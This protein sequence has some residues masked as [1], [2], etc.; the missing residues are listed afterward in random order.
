M[1]S[2]IDDVLRA[3]RSALKSMLDDIDFRILL[4]KYYRGLY[5]AFRDEGFTPDEAMRILL[6]MG[7]KMQFN[8]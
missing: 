1:D 3:A 8:V 4:A 2:E 7:E 5:I 6:V